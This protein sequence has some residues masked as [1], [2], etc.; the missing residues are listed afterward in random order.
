[1]AMKLIFVSNYYT[2]HQAPICEEFFSQTDSSFSFIETEKMENERLSMG[3]DF[4]EKPS[5]VKDYRVE[6]E[7]CQMLIDNADIVIYGSAPKSLFEYRLKKGKI[8]FF[9]SERI[10]KK[11][12]KW[13][14]WPAHFFRFYFWFRRYSNQYLLAAS[15]FAC[16]D[17]H[18]TY[19][20]VNK[21]FKWGYFPETRIYDDFSMV[22]RKKKEFRLKHHVDVSIL[23]VARLIRLKHPEVM[24]ELAKKLRADG[25]VFKMSIAG[26][27]E[28]MPELKKEIEQN[29]LGKY[30]E[31]LGNVNPQEIRD[32]MEKHDIFLFTSDKNEGWGA[33]LNESMN[34]GCAVVASHAIGSVPFLIDDGLNG[35]IYK[36][37]NTDDAYKKVL[38]LIQDRELLNRISLQAYKT[39]S[40][41]WNAKI[42]AKR[43]LNLASST[44]ICNSL[45]KDGPCSIANKLKNDWL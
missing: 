29:R 43:F 35:M 5:F 17:Y 38:T 10:Y 33:V 22:T 1:M 2:H 37:G 40:E 7:Y 44:S 42:A 21:S 12:F 9:Y 25:I 3:W 26:D 27:G 11:G 18:K 19:T 14:K 13:Y 41:K 28:L 39:I 45:Y 23:W 8:T 31:L 6:P 24:I 15:A 20:F 34:S 36:D 16:A 32:V 4:L 30:I